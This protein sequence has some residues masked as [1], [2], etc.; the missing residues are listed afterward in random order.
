[1]SQYSNLKASIAAVIKENG[2]NEITGNLLQQTL[3][4]MVNSL[5]ANYQ[6]RGIA[7]PTTNPGTPD[8]N[9]FYFAST[10][11]TYT[12]FGG[13]VLADGEIAILKWNG[14][15]SKDSTG[16]ASL[17]KLNQ[18]G[19]EVAT[20]PIVSVSQNTLLIGNTPICSVAG[21][22]YIGAA[23]PSTNPGTPNANVIYSAYTAG[24]YANMG[25]IKV[26]DGE[27]KLITFTKSLSAWGFR[28]IHS[29]S[30]YYKDSGTYLAS[31]TIFNKVY[32]IGRK[33]KVV[34]NSGD[35]TKLSL[36]VNHSDGS[37]TQLNLSS[38]NHTYTFT[39]DVYALNIQTLSNGAGTYDV[40]IFG[41]LSL[42]IIE[43]Q[44]QDMVYKGIAIPSG[45]PDTSRS[46]FY[47]A[48]RVGTYTNFGELVILD[49]EIAFLA[50]TKNTN[51]WS[52]N[53]IT[54]EP[55]DYHY[56]GSYASASWIF[57]Y[58]F[59]TGRKIRI[60]TEQYSKI[61][62]YVNF[63]D[64]TYQIIAPSSADHYVELAK[65][66][67]YVSVY[68]LAGQGGEFDV[69]I[70]GGVTA[71]KLYDLQKKIDSIVAEIDKEGEPDTTVHFTVPVNVDI[72]NFTDQTTS[73]QDSSTIQQDQAVIMLPHNYDKAGKPV[74]L[75]IHCHGAGGYDGTSQTPAVTATTSTIENTAMC[76]YLCANGF[77]V[78][79]T[80]GMPAEW[81]ADNNLLM[82]DN[83]GTPMAIQCY[84]HAY[85]Y[86]IEHFNIKED[87]VV[88]YGASMGGLV[89]TNLL[90]SGAIP[91]R[92]HTMMCP[93]L[94]TF[95]QAWEHPW[96]SPTNHN[97]LGLNYNF[98]KQYGAYVYDEAKMR[99]FNPTTHGMKSFT[100]NGALVPSAGAFDYTTEEL[101]GEVVT[102]YREHPVM[103][104]IW[105]CTNDTTVDYGGSKRFVKAIQNA[106]GMAYLRT[107]TTG[108]HS[109]MTVGTPI[110]SPSGS[111]NYRGTTVSVY[112]A[113]EELFL[114]VKRFM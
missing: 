17:E 45:T 88:L 6:F 108:A 29:N 33:V 65:D 58:K 104:K 75:F 100:S 35:Y 89:S 102:E 106:G 39:K 74:P 37:Y 24:I 105:H 97:V 49:G 90:M 60:L 34:V 63:V 72:D 110:S 32:M 43:M 50:Y 25:N 113:V 1:M 18:L 2:N 67:T 26:Y 98:P 53:P 64:G 16:A 27:L 81:C 47:L 95:N 109:P 52:K 11:G 21:Y 73:L 30:C 83:L 84:I 54:C 44:D 14:A 114:F 42:D 92:A 12:N 9:V 85:K 13:W 5:G 101:N 20:I 96:Y 86:A 59:F 79:D 57:Q 91:V 46:C 99:G 80:N 4:A 10:P 40:E 78:L 87:G 111:T 77:A 62:V 7:A 23:F 22:D 71:L 3:L 8:Q 82:S 68:V 38:A 41:G 103:L 56:T 31:A 61:N 107:F 76:K 19:Q 28:S 51:S 48:S 66:T 69:Q 55:L 36:I 94:D 15:W 70:L 112:P 93:C